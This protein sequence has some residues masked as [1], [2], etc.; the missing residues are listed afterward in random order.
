MYTAW[1]LS[2]RWTVSSTLLFQE[3]GPGRL[4][5]SLQWINSPVML[6]L[7]TKREPLGCIRD[8]H[9]SFKTRKTHEGNYQSRVPMATVQ[10]DVCLYSRDP[11]ETILDVYWIWGGRWVR[12]NTHIASTKTPRYAAPNVLLLDPVICVRIEEDP[13]ERGR[14]H[15]TLGMLLLYTCYSVII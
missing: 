5:S 13:E 7:T 14:G 1:I 9:S 15:S 11:P 10:V 2:D 3:K 6:L 4:V 12:I 8:L